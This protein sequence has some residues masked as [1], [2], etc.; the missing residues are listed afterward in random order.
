MY[1]QVTINIS[2]HCIRAHSAYDMQKVFIAL[3]ISPPH[4]FAYTKRIC[5]ALEPLIMAIEITSHS[6]GVKNAVPQHS[7]CYVLVFLF[8]CH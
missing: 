3:R 7:T 2:S 4:Y 8:T 1:S 6:E 5:T